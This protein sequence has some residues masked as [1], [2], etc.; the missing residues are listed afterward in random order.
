MDIE[1]K[2]PRLPNGKQT[3]IESE[4]EK[5][6]L[7]LE[8]DAPP[9]EKKKR[10]GR[11]AKKNLQNLQVE[12]EKAEVA[13]QKS[14]KK[15]STKT[16]AAEKPSKNKQP[17][18]EIVHLDKSTFYYFAKIKEL[19]SLITTNLLKRFDKLP[20]PSTSDDSDSSFLSDSPRGKN[21]FTKRRRSFEDEIFDD[22]FELDPESFLTH[23]NRL[24]SGTSNNNLS[25]TIGLN[26]FQSLMEDKVRETYILFDGAVSF[27]TKYHFYKTLCLAYPLSKSLNI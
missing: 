7:A 1:K 3:A 4:E 14:P 2:S 16:A 5:D 19:N 8:E 26:L 17:V 22:Y 12:E 27:F 21:G 15:S 10:R 13:P 9:V 23:W 20:I 11:W 25:C 24:E 6:K 18:Q